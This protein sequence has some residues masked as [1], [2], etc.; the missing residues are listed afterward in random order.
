MTA[1]AL[2]FKGYSVKEQSYKRNETF[3]QTV[4]KVTLTPQ[5]ALTIE[6]KVKEDGLLVNLGVKVGSL[7]DAPFEVNVQVCG[8]FVYHHEKDTARVGVDT[9]IRRNAVA[10]LYPY[11]RSLVSNLTNTSNEYPA[12]ILPTIDVAQVLKEQPGASELAD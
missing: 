7:T 11:V 2:E 5:I 3:N 8:E 1:T 4:Q 10:I 12:C 6:N 9:L